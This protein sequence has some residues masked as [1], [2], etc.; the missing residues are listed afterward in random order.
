MN[1]FNLC[2][3]RITSSGRKLPSDCINIIKEYL[4][5]IQEKV[6]NYPPNCIFNFDESS[7]Y[8]DAVGNYSI[9]QIGTFTHQI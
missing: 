4:N 9:E 7:F 1:R 2:Q 6:K 8:M 3:R 5:S